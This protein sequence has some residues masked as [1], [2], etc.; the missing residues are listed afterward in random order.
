[1]KCN[2]TKGK[3]SYIA[4]QGCL[5]NTISDFWRMVFQENSRVIVMTTKE[6]ERGKVSG[7]VLDAAGRFKRGLVGNYDYVP[8]EQVCEVLARH[9]GPEGIRGHA[10]PQRQGDG[11]PRLH[12]KRA[13]TVQSRAGE[14]VCDS[15][16]HLRNVVL[17]VFNEQ[18]FPAVVLQKH[19]RKGFAVLTANFGLRAF[20]A[21]QN[22]PSGSTTL[23]PGRTTA[24]P[25]TPVACWTSWRRSI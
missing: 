10:R 14:C 25:L 13:Q 9:V 21:T 6:V 17:M 18:L 16:V 2:S 11:R 20:R 4:T 19:T 7:A 22:A 5:Q 3:K 24:S 8:T 15:N 12:L 23:E 1:M